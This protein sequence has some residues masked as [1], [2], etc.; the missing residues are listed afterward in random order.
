MNG[1]ATLENRLDFP[2]KANHRITIWTSNSTP[3]YTPKRNKNK[4]YQKNF[5]VTVHSSFMN[6]KIKW[7]YIHTRNYLEYYAEITLRTLFRNNAP[8]LMLPLT[9]IIK[10]LIIIN[11][12][13]TNNIPLFLMD[14]LTFYFSI[15]SAA[16]NIHIKTFW[17]YLFLFLLG[18]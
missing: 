17:Q 11:N 10:L 5:Y 15:H 8:L 12:Y 3:T 7:E 6:G 1:A 13:L 4:Y 2:Q 16:M 18:I 14:I 9:I